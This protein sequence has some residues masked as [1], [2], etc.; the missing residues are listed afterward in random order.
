[1]FYINSIDISRFFTYVHDEITYIQ[2]DYEDAYENPP[3]HIVDKEVLDGEVV[4]YNGRRFTIT[5]V[6]NIVTDADEV[7]EDAL[8]INMSGVMNVYCT[9]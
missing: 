6:N 1:M 3:V 7:P 9:I 4:T 8:L 5:N 2:Y